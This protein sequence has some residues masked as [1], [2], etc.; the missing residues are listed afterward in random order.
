[1]FDFGTMGIA[2][3]LPSYQLPMVQ[4]GAMHKKGATGLGRSLRVIDC[5]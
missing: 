4:T 3:L 1:M 2:A 5:K